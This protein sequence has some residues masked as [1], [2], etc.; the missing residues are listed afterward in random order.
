M[1]VIGGVFSTR[2]KLP[3]VYG[4][5]QFRVDYNRMGLTHLFSTT[6]VRQPVLC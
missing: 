2:F 5:Y 6:Q 4:V 3:D 1:F